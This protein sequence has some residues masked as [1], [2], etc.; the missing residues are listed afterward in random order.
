VP[1]AP[2]ATVETPASPPPAGDALA[3]LLPELPAPPHDPQAAVRAAG[4]VALSLLVA[5]A[6]VLFLTLQMWFGRRDPRMA[7][8]PVDEDEDLIGFG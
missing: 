6:V 7:A 3:P 8:A 1:D 5:T 4:T 2:P